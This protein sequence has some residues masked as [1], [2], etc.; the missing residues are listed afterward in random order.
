ML[1]PL[2][3]EAATRTYFTLA[4]LQ[5]MSEWWH[6][7]LLAGVGLAALA[8][9]AVVYWMDSVELRPG[10]AAAL[11][12]LRLLA[13]AGLLIFFLEVEKRTERKLIK[14]SRAL[15]LVDTSQSM[16]LQDTLDSST[17]GASRIEQV[18]AAF[19]QGELLGDLRK[20]HDVVVYRFDQ[21]AQPVEIASF[22]KSSAG[23]TSA[24]AQ[25][26]QDARY[27]EGLQEVRLLGGVALAVFALSLAASVAYFLMLRNGAYATAAS[28][29]LSSAV[30]T[31]I[32]ALALVGIANLRNPR[33]SL[34]AAAGLKEPSPPAPVETAPI[35]TEDRQ[36]GEEAPTADPDDVNWAEHLVARGVETRIGEALRHVVNKERGGPVAGVIL[37]TD[38]GENAGVKTSAVLPLAQDAGVRVY[39]VGVGSDK[40][41]VNVR[42]VD[43][44][45]PPRVYPGDDFGITAFIQ[46]FG[47]EPGRAVRVELASGAG[48][49]ETNLT[50]EDEVRLE[51]GD[52]G[53]V[54]PVKFEVTPGEPGRRVYRVRV[55]GIAQEHDPRDNEKS[56]AVQVVERKNKVLLFAGGPMREYQFL[57]NLLFRDKDTTLHVLLQSGTPQSYQEGDV[58]LDEFPRTPE[59]MFEYDCV[60]AFDPDWRMLD[61]QQVDVLERWI[62]EKAGG[63]ITVAGPVFTPT[64]TGGRREDPRLQTIKGLYPVTFYDRFSPT[65]RL[66][67]FGS[68]TSWNLD[69]TR[70][71]N[72]AEFLWLEDS[73]IENENA[74]LSFAGV[75]GYYATKEAKPG[76]AVYAY[77]SDPS[78]KLDDQLP[79][80]MA[81]H[82]YGAGR[83]FFQASGEM[84]RVRAIDDGY[85]ERYYTKLIRW[86]SQGRL[87]RDSNRGV[88]LVDKE[89]ALIGDQVAIRANLTD[90]Q[91]NP[92]TVEEVQAVLVQPDGV[93]KPLVLRKIKDAAREGMYAGQFTTA[94][95]GDY[96][97]ELPVPQSPDDEL[98]TRE[99]RVRVPDREIERPQRNDALLRNIADRTKG[100]YY[101]GLASAVGRGSEGRVPLATAI[102]PRDQETF[103][104]GALDQTFERLLAGWLMA[105]V[106][107]VLFMEWTIRRLHKLA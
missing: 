24:E 53:D 74:W 82:F 61:E 12:V 54:I 5:Y 9:I 81:G 91:F 102:T 106:C 87:L 86:A 48:D 83:V 73:Q 75:Y 6:W 105:L 7:L 45:A 100:D 20:K 50:P 63:L 47:L 94:M 2:F 17:G 38:G 79:I 85:F 55:S 98:L 35:T 13:F 36:G 14:N 89:R 58:M 97:L 64:W 33:V 104:S 95:E 26:E 41:P 27:R 43:V 37:V 30:I 44:E 28:W 66:G 77:F 107:G 52:E 69:F 11:L 8:F 56:A 59:E 40:T 65:L 22:A 1:S 76:A 57:R 46:S 51:L 80:Y 92:L 18:M 19:T 70:E 90:P 96:R 101:I 39:P 3:A 42:V 72:E 49:D 103:L 32:A 15:V 23:A 10:V 71:G 29:M 84:W 60:V 4:R 99:V 67:R 21:T 93:R 34:L 68:E 88:L 16:G 31:L 25:V 78:T 62:A